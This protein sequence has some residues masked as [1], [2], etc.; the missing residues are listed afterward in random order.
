MTVGITNV[1]GSKSNDIKNVESGLFNVDDYCYYNNNIAF[2][3][4]RLTY[5][6][7]TYNTFTTKPLQVN[8]S[9]RGVTAFS[10]INNIKSIFSSSYPPSSST[11]TD[12][13][14]LMK[15]NINIDN[16]ILKPHN[17][18]IIQFKAGS[19]VKIF[20]YI[21]NVRNSSYYPLVIK[22]NVTSE[23]NQVYIDTYAIANDDNTLTISN[24]S[25]NSVYT[26]DVSIG[27]LRIIIKSA[28]GESA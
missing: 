28:I 2:S 18:S 1:S 24:L 13:L 10:K 26:T 25:I 7:Q 17:N 20:G 8:T 12:I 6:S 15:N 14:Q 27:N 21:E 23:Y 19:K 11:V 9:T 16:I 5:S 3:S 4:D 22:N